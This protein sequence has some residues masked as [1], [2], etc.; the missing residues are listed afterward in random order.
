VSDNAMKNQEIK[1]VFRSRVSVLL[2][3]FLSVVFIPTTILIFR[4]MII[5]SLFIMGGTLL[6]VVLL[7]SGMRYIISG[8]KLYVKIW[9][10]PYKSIKIA[11]I[12]S[13]ERSYNLLASPTA[14]LKRLKLSIGNGTMFS[15]ILISPVKEQE[16]IETLKEINPYINVDVTVKKEVWRIQDWDI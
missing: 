13:I 2:L 10:I 14:S 7:F 15:D 9:V 4:D 11:D 12:V 8:N 6:F 1:K 16:F 5:S 3:A